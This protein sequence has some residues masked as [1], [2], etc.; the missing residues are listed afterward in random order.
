MRAIRRLSLWPDGEREID[1]VRHPGRAGKVFVLRFIKF[2]LPHVRRA[3]AAFA[4]HW[5]PPGG[6]GRE[7]RPDS[8]R[9]GICAA[10]TL[11]A[12]FA[13]PPGPELEQMLRTSRM[14][15]DLAR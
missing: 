6:T 3:A 2:V 4:L 1:G 5:R 12:P 7:R 8:V 10:M 11:L 15:I 9:S 13:T 14:D